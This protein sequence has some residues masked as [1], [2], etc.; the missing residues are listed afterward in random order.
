MSFSK[1]YKSYFF[2]Q[3]NP[4]FQTNRINRCTQKITKHEIWSSSINDLEFATYFYKRPQ[5]GQPRLENGQLT[6]GHVYEPCL[7]I[8]AQC[9]EIIPFYCM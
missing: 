1:K 3:K 7:Q 5:L 6:A 4:P 9:K 8:T 2:Q